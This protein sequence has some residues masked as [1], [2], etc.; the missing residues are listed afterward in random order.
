MSDAQQT[1]DTVYVEM[2]A[3]EQPFMYNRLGAAQPTGMVFALTKDLDTT[4]PSSGKI[5]DSFLGTVRLNSNKRPRPIVL[6][7]NE[8]DILKIKFTNL[9]SK[10]DGTAVINAYGTDQPGTV[11]QLTAT[12]N[13]SNQGP[14]GST[15]QRTRSAGVHI[16]G[17][18][19]VSSILSDGSNA[20]FNDSSLVQPGG[21][22]TYTLIVPKEGVYMLYST[23][24]QIAPGGQKGGQLSNGLFGSLNVE[25]RGAEWYRSQVSEEDMNQA[26]THYNKVNADGTITKIAKKDVPNIYDTDSIY[27]NV[28]YDANYANGDPILKMYKKIGSN[29]KQ[30]MYTDLTAII[31]GPG[32]GDFTGDGPTFFPVP[33]SPDRRQSFREISIHYHESPY[34]VQAFP[35]SYEATRD[36]I[37][38]YGKVVSVSNSSVRGTIAYNKVVTN[39]I[40]YFS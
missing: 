39:C 24:A 11:D 30:L 28:D 3:I 14:T 19:M 18:E 10:Y 35:I 26:I 29:T 36:S 20:G 1:R 15:F 16:M 25:P 31:T 22:I 32:R 2:A 21:T 13:S 33:A 23:A 4:L 6:R 38:P 12:S 7:A 8:G 5:P 34:T 9:L 40:F 37:T 27:P 17:T